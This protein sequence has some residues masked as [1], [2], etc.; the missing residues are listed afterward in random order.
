MRCLFQF[1]ILQA[2]DIFQLGGVV[3]EIVNRLFR[4]EGRRKKVGRQI[5]TGIEVFTVVIVMLMVSIM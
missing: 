5:Y 3:P 1:L 2:A 4:F